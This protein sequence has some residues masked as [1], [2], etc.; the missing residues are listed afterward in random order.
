LTK[1]VRKPRGKNIKIKKCCCGRS[2]FGTHKVMPYCYELFHLDFAKTNSHPSSLDPTFLDNDVPVVK[3]FT[4][5]ITNGTQFLQK[6]K[7]RCV[8]KIIIE[9]QFYSY[10][11]VILPFL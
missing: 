6:K 2:E 9:G 7:S 3:L 5:F 11:T 4:L 8:R 1:I 10:T